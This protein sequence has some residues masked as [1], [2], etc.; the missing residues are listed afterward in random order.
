MAVIRD[1]DQTIIDFALPWDFILMESMFTIRILTAT[2][3]PR[4]VDS[5]SGARRRE[6]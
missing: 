6:G 3:F 2:C 5:I 1:H 4:L